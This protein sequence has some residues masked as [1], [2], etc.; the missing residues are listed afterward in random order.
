ML[1]IPSADYRKTERRVPPKLPAGLDALVHAGIG[2]WKRRSKALTR[3]IDQTRTAEGHEPEFKSLTDHQLRD[4]LQAFR[5]EFRRRDD[6]APTILLPALAAVREAAFRTLGLHPFPV[7]LVGALVLRHGALAEMATGEGKTLTAGLAAVLTG[8]GGRPL[9]IITANDYLVERDSAWL[10]P[11]YKFCGLRAGHVTSALDPQARRLGYAADITYTTSKEIVADFLR[12]RLRLGLLENPRK[13]LLHGLIQPALFNRPDVV[14]RG[15]HTAI[16]DEAD[17]L[18]ID[19][20][21]TPLIISAPQPNELLVQACRSAQDL[22]A[23][24]QPGVDYL[25]QPR[26][27]EVELLE[28]GKLKLAELSHR[29]PGIFQ[30]LGRRQELI[31]QALV[32]REFFLNGRQYVLLDGKV[33]IVDEFTGRIM[34]NRSW[35]AGLH[36]AVEAKEGLHVSEPTETLARLSF[37]RFFRFFKKLSGMTGT[38]REAASE[39]WQVYGLPVIPIPTHKPCQRVQLPDRIF[40]YSDEKWSAIEEE[41]VRIHPSNRPILVGTRSVHASEQLATRLEKRGL[42]FRVLNAVRHLEEAQVIAEAGQP[43]RITLATNMAGRGTDIRLG[44]GVAERGGLHVIASERH[45]SARIDRQLFG[46]SARQGDPGSAQAFVSAEDDLL[47]RHLP[48]S[49]RRNL[50]PGNPLSPQLI[51]FA[52]WRAERFA[53]EQRKNVLKTDTWMDDALSFASS[54][55]A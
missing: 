25:P 13:R 15:L 36:Q 3:F 44:Q 27:R 10:Q 53:F 21:V 45:E 40:A 8:W 51:R 37:Q 1:A 4:R 11:L 54:P 19:E 32:A 20:A 38:A 23:E 17:S 49:L 12:D 7:Q 14:M 31:Q 9:H 22:A 29:L 35:R 33:V 48:S 34:P 46:R 50:T 5:T 2:T 28:P 47:I 30:S 24:L 42:P 6:V 18:L 55:S 16:V 43:G 26:F 41:I 39:L 52:Q